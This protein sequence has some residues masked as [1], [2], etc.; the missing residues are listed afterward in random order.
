MAL[1]RVS[2]G[3]VVDATAQTAVFLRY[4]GL[5]AEGRGGRIAANS[6]GIATLTVDLPD[7][8][9]VYRLVRGQPPTKS[10]TGASTAYEPPKA[11]T[12]LEVNI[13]G[14]Q[15]VVA[16]PDFA[17]QPVAIAVLDNG[18]QLVLNRT[19]DG[20]T[21]VAGTFTGP[22]SRLEVDGDWA[23]AAARGKLG[24]FRRTHP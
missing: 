21:R 16:V 7:G 15:A 5:S 11:D 10:S 19:T 12:G 20:S 8:S 22:V 18:T 3:S 17:D 23:L 2:G 1:T 24:V 9:E 6:D 4:A 13:E 14:L